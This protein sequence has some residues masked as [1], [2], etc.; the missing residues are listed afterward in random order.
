MR[1]MPN[2]ISTNYTNE[3]VTTAGSWTW[4]TR[5][6]ISRGEQTAEA[7]PSIFLPAEE[8][9]RRIGFHVDPVK[10]ETQVSLRIVEVY[11]ADPN[12]YLPLENRILYEGVRHI[13]D[14]D[15]QELFFKAFPDVD[16]E[17]HNARRVEFEDDE[18][19]KLKPARIRDLEMRVV[20]IAEF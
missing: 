12:E 19:N 1:E 17:S 15:N 13:T 11:I 16:L 2:T 14:D 4:P 20:V 8:L 9:N 6:R 10:E 7:E 3:A 18:G 5:G